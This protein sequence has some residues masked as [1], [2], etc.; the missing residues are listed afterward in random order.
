MARFIA[1]ANQKGGVGK[2]TTAVNLCASIALAGRTCLLI[3][4]DP[5]GNATTGLGIEKRSR[6]GTHLLLSAPHRAKEA[7]VQTQCKGLDMIPSGPGLADAE[8][9]H[10]SIADRA[11]R[12]R[13]SKPELTTLYDY[14]FVDCPPSVGFFPANAL[15]CCDSVLIPIQCEYYAMEGLAQILSR[16]RSA[17]TRFNPQL[18]VEGILLTMYESSAF[19]SEVVEEV[20]THFEDLVYETIIPRNIALAEAPSHG[21][22]I[23]DY[24]HRSRGARAYLELA[25][26]VLNN[27]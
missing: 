4:L 23:L 16:I 6:R 26:E 10:G 8:P 25:K 17:K 9:R 3:D 11:L 20:R 22:A 14:V 12:L 13:A 24:D 5:Q 2:T 18:E 19:S 15:S 27:G 21:Q 1:V 7:I